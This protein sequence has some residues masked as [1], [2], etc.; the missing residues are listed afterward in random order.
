MK[1]GSDRNGHLSFLIERD[2][3]RG[4]KERGERERGERDRGD[5]HRKPI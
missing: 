4:K 3:E 1:A 5:D 2:G